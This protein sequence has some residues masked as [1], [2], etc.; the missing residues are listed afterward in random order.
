M[1][2]RFDNDTGFFLGP[3][4]QP[5]RI[6]TIIFVL[7]RG[8][9]KRI[10]GLDMPLALLAPSQPE[11]ESRFASVLA[12]PMREMSLGTKPVFTQGVKSESRAIKIF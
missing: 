2:K 7:S 8:F 6:I 4:K 5:S 12:L 9:R 3:L 10:R 1:E 11:V